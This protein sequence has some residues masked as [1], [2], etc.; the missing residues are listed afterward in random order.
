MPIK[1]QKTSNISPTK[2]SL[3][4]QL[5]EQK[6]KIKVLQ[7]KSRI[8]EKQLTKLKSIVHDMK[9]KNLISIESA[10]KLETHFSGLDRELITNHEKN[11]D[12]VPVGRYSDEVK[13]FA[14]TLHFYSPRAYEF[15]RNVFSLPHASSLGNWTSTVNCETGFFLDVFQ[16]LQKKV[17]EEIVNAD[18][19]LL[20]DAM[21]IKSGTIYNRVTDSYDGFVNGEDIIGFDEDIVATEALVFMLVGL[22][23]SWK[24]PIGY[25]LT[26]K[27]NASNLHCL[28]SRALGNALKHDLDVHSIT[29]D[30][31]SSNLGTMI[32]FDCKLGYSAKF[33][34]DSFS[35]EVFSHDLYIFPDAP[36]MLK[37][38][39]NAMA[40][41]GVLVDE[42]AYIKWDFIRILH[43]RQLDEG[44]KFGDKLSAR[45]IEFQRHKM[46]VKVAAQTLSSSVADAIEFLME[47][48]HPLF[49]GADATIYFIRTINRI[50]DLLNSKKL[51]GTGFKKPLKLEDKAKWM[52]VIDVGMEYL[53]KLRTVSGQPIL[54]HRRKTFVLG[55][56][57]ALSSLKR[58]AMYLLSHPHYPFQYFLTYKLSQDHLELL[59]ACIRGKNEF[60]NNPDV[61]QLK[62]ALKKIL[63]RVSII[64]SKHYNCMVF[65]TDISPIFSLKWTKSRS[66][67]ADREGLEENLGSKGS[68]TEESLSYYVE[69]SSVLQMI[70]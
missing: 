31:T 11:K 20:C 19:A 70:F 18:C 53:E 64:A 67:M 56:I 37:L 8:K 55:F 13:R 14:M 45:H 16:E 28:L 4:L 5:A 69:N 49:Q 21:Q 32:K 43:E 27:V 48:D 12:R 50:F 59:F 61:R 42:K 22:R 52:K 10:N 41:L 26:D 35:F 68:V 62:S 33:I 30:G 63:L 51:K 65:E 17:K 54:Q 29:M 34:D 24:Y 23:S 58:Q 15:V 66:P 25:V 40:D 60:N 57:T 47:N 44:L 6:V 7:Q 2:E 38:A 46:K 36:H 1:S 3:K 9:K 39:R